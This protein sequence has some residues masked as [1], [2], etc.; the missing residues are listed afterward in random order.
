MTYLEIPYL[1]MGYNLCELN[2]NTTNVIKLYFYRS[3]LRI[4]FSAISVLFCL[5]YSPIEGV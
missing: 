2:R 4:K 3:S 5:K 1:K